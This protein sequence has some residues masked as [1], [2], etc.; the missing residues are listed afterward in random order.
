MYSKVFSVMDLDIIVA[1]VLLIILFLYKR[2][3]NMNENKNK[4]YVA[5]I[6][7]TVALI[8]IESIDKIIL[9]SSSN[10]L[11]PVT[12]VINVIGLILGPI[13][14]Y[15]WIMYLLKSFSKKDTS[16]TTKMPILINIVF[17]FFSFWQGFI[18]IIEEN[19]NYIRGPLFFIPIMTICT[20]FIISL[21]IVYNNR[22]NISAMQHAIL[23]IFEIMPI[24]T[25]GL[26]VFFRELYFIGGVIGLL[27]IVHYIYLQE[28]MSKYD[29]LTGV[30]NRGTFEAYVYNNYI[31][32]SRAFSLVYIDVNDFKEINDQYGHSEGDIALKNISN[33]LK[34]CFHV[35]GKV[36]R[37]GGDEFLAVTEDI[38]DENLYNSVK[39]IN[40]NIS[41]LNKTQGKDY[42]LNVS[43]GYKVFNNEY[44]NLADYIREIDK[45]MYVDKRSRK[46]STAR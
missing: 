18:F 25:I 3:F 13:I 22:K 20:Y 30:W 45:L 42:N 26:Q 41:R 5:M 23:I 7:C 27:I 46:V 38:Y 10:L 2:K 8:F 31:N 4:N 1:I 33:V 17:C 29:N 16:F 12:K 6:L 14:P 37:I 19:N 28:L 21:L 24:L 36:S 15:L 44:D 34:R 9:T 40:K 32:K 43:L 11:I 39:N 35:R